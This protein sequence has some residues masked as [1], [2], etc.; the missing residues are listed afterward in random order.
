MPGGHPA[1]ENSRQRAHTEDS[2]SRAFVD[3]S[4]SESRE[5]DAPELKIPLPPGAKNYVTPEGAARTRAELDALLQA[6]QPRLREAERRIQYLSRMTAIMEVV[7][8]SP[9][10]AARV[11]FGAAVTVRGQDGTQ[12]VYRI[13][14]VDESDPSRG[15]VSWVSPIARALMGKRPG[16]TVTV[17]LPAGQAALTVVSI[18]G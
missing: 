8:P 3:E 7:S 16:D 12:R 15:L 9:G 1:L 13:V 11:A 10:P 6:P 18:S 17:S 4:A 5:G 2:M 14:G